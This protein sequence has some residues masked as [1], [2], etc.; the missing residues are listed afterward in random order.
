ME[1]DVKLSLQTSFLCPL[2]PTAWYTCFIT[3]YQS[4]N[5][6]FF[7]LPQCFTFRIILWFYAILHVF[8]LYSHYGDS[9]SNKRLALLLP[10]LLVPTPFTKGGGFGQTPSYLKSHCPYEREICMVLETHLKV[11]E[12]LKLFTYYLLGYHSNSSKER[13]LGGKSVDFSRK[14]Q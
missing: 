6:K 9:I 14:Y 7:E 10:S 13:C 1:V 8:V 2:P 12:M 3:I 5:V 4:I 11:L